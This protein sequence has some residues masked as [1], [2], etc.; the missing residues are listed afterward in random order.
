MTKINGALTVNE[1]AKQMT[2]NTKIYGKLL[3]E[4]LPGVIDSKEEYLRIERLFNDLIDKGED[5]FSPEESRLF[6]L[7]ANLMENYEQTVLPPLLESSS[8]LE[9][10]KFLM[11][12]NNLKQKDV[13]IIF[14]SQG[15]AS[16]VLAGKRRIGKKHAELLA[17]KF[18]VSA[19]LFS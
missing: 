15:I 1:E 10:L 3:A 13:V 16:E 8:P 9:T 18:N 12:E 14:G 6:N 11:S 17:E 2:F 7:L 4:T 5:N 19:Q